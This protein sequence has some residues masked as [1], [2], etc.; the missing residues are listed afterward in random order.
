LLNYALLSQVIE[1]ANK[2][3]NTQETI[4]A[5]DYSPIDNSGWAQRTRLHVANKVSDAY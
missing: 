2:A 1:N 4:N 3:Q 5:G